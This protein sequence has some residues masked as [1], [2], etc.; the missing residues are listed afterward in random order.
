MNC[1]ILWL[2]RDLRVHDHRPLN[3]AVAEGLP[4]QPIF[5]FDRNILS[6]FNNKNDRRLSFIADSLIYLQKKIQQ[7][8]GEI[9]VFYGDP[10]EVIIEVA[11]KLQARKVFAGED[12]EPQTLIRDQKIAKLLKDKGKELILSVDHLILDPRLIKKDNNTPYQVFSFY[13]KKWKEYISHENYADYSVTTQGKYLDLQ[14]V[15]GLK[16]IPLNQGVEFL[17]SKVGYNYQTDLFVKPE[18]AN[19]AL[20]NFISTG[21]T[22]YNEQR[23][24]FAAKGTSECSPYIRFG[25]IS[26]RECY[27]KAIEHEGAYSWIKELI[28]REFFAMMLYRYPYVVNTEFLAEYRDLKWGDNKELLNRFQ[29]GLT[30]YPLVDAAMRQLKNTGWMHNRARMIVASFLT[31]MLFIDWRLG[32]EHFAQYLLDYELSSNIGNWQWAA[33]VGTDPQ[34]YF[35]VFSPVLQSKKFDPNGDYIRMYVPEL[36]VIKDHLIHTPHIYRQKQYLDYPDYMVSFEMAKK[37]VRAFFK[38]ERKVDN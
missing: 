34:P 3:Q 26:I 19:R 13:A 1:S 15:Q 5:I 8:K 7:D 32:E 14:N 22:N 4:V 38:K 25:L 6:R 16:N 2:R 29:E 27:R 23:N 28:W 36:R 33:S 11:T 10:E 30:G 18:N 20:Q 31:K 17:L 35:R 37:L 9:L 24:F 12:F 21:L